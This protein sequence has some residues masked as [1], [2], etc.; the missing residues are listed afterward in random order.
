MRHM[1]KTMCVTAMLVVTAPDAN[2]DPALVVTD[3]NMRSA[4]STGYAVMDT[5]PGG[6]IVNARYCISNGWCRVI[7]DGRRGWV[8]GRYLRTER[9]A[10][11][12]APPPPVFFG[13]P[14]PYFGG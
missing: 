7:W 12:L 1:T 10:D 5:I 14:P 9:F 3:L 13:S 6:T 11:R 4:P 2:A 8:S